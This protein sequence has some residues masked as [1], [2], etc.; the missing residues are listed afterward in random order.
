[1]QPSTGAKSEEEWNAC[2]AKVELSSLTPAPYTTKKK[3]SRGK[4][5]SLGSNFGCVGGN[6]TKGKL[7]RFFRAEL[8]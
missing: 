4:L 6:G 1:M 3:I 2:A 8:C 7:G 5:N